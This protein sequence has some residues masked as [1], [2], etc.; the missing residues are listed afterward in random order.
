M[1][2][3]SKAKV[4]A[5]VDS[6]SVRS[7]VDDFVRRCEIEFLLLELVSTYIGVDNIDRLQFVADIA[8]DL[9]VFKLELTIRG[10]K[11]K[12]TPADLY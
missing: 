6:I 4:Y 2:N 9:S 1:L 8:H 11:V 12:V 7:T 3:V 5:N 10:R